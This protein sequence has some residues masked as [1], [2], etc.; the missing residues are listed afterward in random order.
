MYLAM[1]PLGP[2][3]TEYSTTSR[4]GRWW[5]F[6]FLGAMMLL[7]GCAA[8]HWNQPLD[9]ATVVPRYDF[10][11]RMPKDN[12]QDV[13]VVLAFSGGGTRSAA[14]SYGVLETLRDTTVTLHGTSRRLLDEVDVITATSGGSYTAAYYGLFGDR[15]FDDFEEK[16]LKRNV[17][18]AFTRLLLN[19]VNLFSIARPS[20]NRG[21]LAARWLDDRVFENRTFEDMS[22]GSLP[23][24][25]INAS[26]LNTGITFSF[27]QQQ[28]DFLCSDANRFL[29][30]NA[31]MA[32]S[33]VPLVFGPV[34]VMNFPTD[35]ESR[36][37]SWVTE[38]IERGD[39]LTRDYQ[40]ARGLVRY[41]EPDDIPVIRLFD[42]GLTDNL[43]VRGSMMSPVAHV[44]N[45]QDMAGAFDQDA[46]DA[47]T[48]VL[49]IVAN[50]QIYAHP[51]WSSKGREPHILSTIRASFD[52][53]LNILNTETISL[54][55]RDFRMWGDRINARRT[56]G[57][58]NV[59][60]HFA[61]LT[62]Q[63]I[64][65]PAERDYFNSLPTS[66]S[67]SAEQ[68]D[69]T[70]SV[71]RRLLENSPAFQEFVRDLP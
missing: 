10:A 2:S 66:M 37:A 59:N 16:F 71:A 64:E 65:E 39:V 5:P 58:P 46:L 50:A 70:R 8:R 53:A 54:A 38:A 48:T 14:F 3:R 12:A 42:G 41:F 23:F 15:L 7:T 21:D 11:N 20:Y 25:I 30:A 45:V 55:E 29:V 68:V 49:V 27:M 35:C 61:T 31:V 17:Q 51:E 6:V 1:T 4:L 28:F 56:K 40:V 69:R 32:S 43:G 57:S 24:V 9:S 47:V 19:P 62:F 33:A 36:R 63:H 26:D 22:L 18:G 44:G 34:S 60:I 13:F 52:A 67:L